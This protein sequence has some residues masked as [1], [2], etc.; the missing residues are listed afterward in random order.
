MLQTPSPGSKRKQKADQPPLFPGDRYTASD[1]I[2][3]GHG[4]NAFDQKPCNFDLPDA[5]LAEEAELVDAVLR[6][7]RKATAEFVARY[8]DRIYAYLRSRLAPRY[9]LVDDLVQE[10][11]LAAWQ[12]LGRYRRDGPLQ[13]W[14]LGIARHKVEDHYRA[15]LRTPES[16]GDQNDED[17]ALA[18][19]PEFDLSLEQEQM[20][21]NTWRVLTALPD[22][23]RMALIWRYWDR[24]SARE[25]AAKTGRTEKAVERLLARA[26]DEFR[27]RWN[28]G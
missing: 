6:K 9:D 22:Q 7:D 20:R 4:L 19:L 10:V 24:A 14:I 8:A 28:R 26:R 17:H 12:S 2:S 13:A 18:F 25:M 21:K 23:Y 5:G 1:S 11:F 16:F 15:C 27:E 3:K